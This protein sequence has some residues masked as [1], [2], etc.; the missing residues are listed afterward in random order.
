MIY[1]VY[2]LVYDIFI[3]I[4]NMGLSNYYICLFFILKYFLKKSLWSAYGCECLYNLEMFE[5]IGIK[6][7]FNYIRKSLK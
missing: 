7:I 1:N 6:I 2:I 3:S 4:D 5:L